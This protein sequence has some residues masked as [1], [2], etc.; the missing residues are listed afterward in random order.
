[1]AARAGVG[2]YEIEIY[3]GA[4]FSNFSKLGY[5]VG[6][7]H[8]S[9]AIPSVSDLRLFEFSDIQRDA[10]NVKVQPRDLSASSPNQNSLSS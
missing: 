5:Y 10:Q 6:G 7:S 4:K 3:C 9:N 2:S 1:M 8:T